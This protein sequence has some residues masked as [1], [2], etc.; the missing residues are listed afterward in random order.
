MKVHLHKINKS[1]VIVDYHQDPREVYTQ[2]IFSENRFNSSSILRAVHTLN[3]S[4]TQTYPITSCYSMT[5]LQEITWSVVNAE[6]WYSD[7]SFMMLTPVYLL[8]I[9][10][11]IKFKLLKKKLNL[12]GK[13]RNAT[14]LIQLVMTSLWG[15]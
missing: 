1:A 13:G 15:I 4:S 5:E 3:P 7:M 14:C 2:I 8:L 10:F 9:H 11:R 6:V 12:F